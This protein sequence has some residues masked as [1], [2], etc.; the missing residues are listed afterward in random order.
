MFNKLCCRDADYSQMNT[1]DLEVVQLQPII[2]QNELKLCFISCTYPQR[3]VT[4]FCLHPT[5]RIRIR[6]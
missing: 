4:R 6:S 2:D 5:E 1:E 3:N